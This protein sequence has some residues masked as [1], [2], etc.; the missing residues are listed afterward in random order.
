MATP[1]IA[2]GAYARLAR[3]TDAAAGLSKPAGLTG[4]E[5]VIWLKPGLF[6]GRKP[7]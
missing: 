1:G 7:G 3:I 4:S 5:S 6:V 2:A